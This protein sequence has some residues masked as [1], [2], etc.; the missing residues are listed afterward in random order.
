MMLFLGPRSELR[1][2]KKICRMHSKKRVT[3]FAACI[4]TM[5]FTPRKKNKNQF[6]TM[7]LYVV[8]HAKEK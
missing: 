3:S 6:F 5:F 1:D 8:V 4:S 2:V 7:L